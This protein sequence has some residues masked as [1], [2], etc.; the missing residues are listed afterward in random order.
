MVHDTQDYLA[1]YVG[2]MRNQRIIMI[3]L[4]WK[5]VL[6]GDLGNEAFLLTLRQCSIMPVGGKAHYKSVHTA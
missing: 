5:L 4:N 6:T 1:L 3:H 2:S